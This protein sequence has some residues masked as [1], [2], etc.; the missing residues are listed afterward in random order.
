[1][2]IEPKGILLVEDD[3]YEI[4]LIHLALD[5]LNIVKPI[6]IAED[7]E[8]AL[9]FLLGTDEHP[10]STLLPRLVW[11]DLKLPK[12]GGIKVLERIRTHP[13][14]HQLAVVVMTSSQED[15]DVKACYDLGV[16]SYIVKPLDFEEFTN[17]A[18][19]VGL[20]WTRLNQ[21]PLLLP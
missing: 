21:P 8:E 7:G 9:K 15:T 5:G 10:P 6:N 3:P 18:R 20:Y 17:V 4:E 12:L 13:R 2:P 14:T 1:M 19:L 11:L 16:N